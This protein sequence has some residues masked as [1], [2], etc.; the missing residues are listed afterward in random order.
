MNKTTIALCN[1][2]CALLGHR[3]WMKE[4]SRCTGK[5]A[6]TTDYSLRWDDGTRMYISNGMS[7]FEEKVKNTVE[8]LKRTRSKEHQEALMEVLREYEKDDAVMAREN[9]LKS[10]KVLGLIEIVDHIGTIWWGV[11]L[12]IDGQTFDFRESG[13]DLDIQAG[14]DK[15]RETKQREAGRKLWTAGGVDTP[16]YVI[17]GVGHSTTYGCYRPQPEYGDKVTFYPHNDSVTL[18]ERLRQALLNV[19]TA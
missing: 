18:A 7:Y 14:A 19:K 8:M 16:D 6:G 13:L 5:W 2:L 3:S 11:R 1:E 4:G 12:D 17:H 15:L 10:Y 9:G